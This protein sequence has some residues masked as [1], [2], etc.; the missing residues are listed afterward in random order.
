M[1]VLLKKIDGS[2]LDILY[3]WRNDPSIYTL[4]ATQQKVSRKEH[5]QWFKQITLDQK[6]FNYIIL[7]ND[8]KCGSVR[9]TYIEE[10]T[11]RISIYLINEFQGKNIGSKVIFILFKEI[12]PENASVVADILKDNIKSYNFFIKNNFEKNNEDG[13]L[14]YLKCVKR[15]IQ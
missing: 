13:Q 8:A 7:Y 14:I 9:L 5:E 15:K 2:D 11:Y 12:V 6:S 1:S 3:T 10:N 4:S